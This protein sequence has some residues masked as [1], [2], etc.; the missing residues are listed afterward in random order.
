MGLIPTTVLLHINVILQV[1]HQISLQVKLPNGFLQPVC[2]VMI[3]HPKT[4][5][6]PTR[7]SSKPPNRFSWDGSSSPRT[8]AIA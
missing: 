8:P 6:A 2:I 7:D 1:I 3:P 5:P 4:Y